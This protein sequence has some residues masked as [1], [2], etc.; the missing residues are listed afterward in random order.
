MKRDFTY[1]DDV[2]EGV[3]RVIAHVPGSTVPTPVKVYFVLGWI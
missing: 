2:I 1:I 3:V